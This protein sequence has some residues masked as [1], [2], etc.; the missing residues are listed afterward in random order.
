[1]GDQ[2]LQVTAEVIVCSFPRGII[3]R[4]GGDEF[5]VV[6]LGDHAM[7]EAVEM[8]RAFIQALDERFCRERVFWQMTVSVG[9]AQAAAGQTI[10]LDELIRRG[11]QA[12]YAAKQQGKGRY[13]VYADKK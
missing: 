6:L 11:D 8:A 12:L 9:L 7:E 10:S 4:M 13:M 5:V 3:A 1:M 2:A